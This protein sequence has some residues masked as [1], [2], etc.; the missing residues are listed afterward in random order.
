[1]NGIERMWKEAVVAYVKNHPVIFLEGQRQST[2]KLSQDNRPP[3]RDL[4]PGTLKYEAGMLTTRTTTFGVP[5]HILTYSI[6]INM[7]F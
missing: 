5:C 2:V 1:V 7:N 6:V 4:K 3:G